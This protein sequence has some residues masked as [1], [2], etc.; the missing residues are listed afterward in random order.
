MGKMSRKYSGPNRAG[1][2]AISVA[3]QVESVRKQKYNTIY[4]GRA[5]GTISKASKSKQGC[6]KFL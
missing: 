5:D 2:T 4:V 6:Q 1:L 3:A